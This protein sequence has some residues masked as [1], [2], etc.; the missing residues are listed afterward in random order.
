MKTIRRNGEILWGESNLGSPMFSVRREDA[1][2]MIRRNGIS[3]W[4]IVG[5]RFIGRPERKDPHAPAFLDPDGVTNHLPSGI[6]S[7]S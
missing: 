2:A 4:Y 5:R 7:E 6:W 3:Y 1:P